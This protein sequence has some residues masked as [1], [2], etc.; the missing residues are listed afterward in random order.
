M[1]AIGSTTD[2]AL[3]V[4]LRFGALMLRAGGTASRTREIMEAMARRL[5]LEAPSINLTIGHVVIS[6]RRGSERLTAM[7][8]VGPPGVNV[9]CIGALERLAG[10]TEPATAPQIAARLTEIEADAP[11]YSAWQIV[12]AVGLASGGFAFLNG[13]GVPELAAAALGGGIGQALRSWLVRRAFTQFGTAALAAITAAAIYVLV[14]A[15]ANR[16]GFTFS[17]YAAG[18]I[19][20]VLFLVPGV[21]LIAGLFDLLQH[22]TMAALG[23]LAYGS[24]ILFIVASGLSIV[25]AFAGIELSRQPP[26]ELPYPL[27]LSLRAVASFIA[28]CAFAMA[29][30]SP[31]RTMLVAGVVALVVNSLRLVL[32]D[33]GMLL[34]PAAFIAALSVG[35][36]ASLASRRF[37]AQ[38]MAIVAAPIV[39]MIPGLYAFEMIVLFNLGRMNE[40][41]QASAGFVFVICALA[42]GLSMARLAVARKASPM[43]NEPPDRRGE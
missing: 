4:L 43:M 21:P 27:Q 25:T 1:S 23:R 32:V 31:P 8:D 28:A 11:H 18:F 5:K 39:I 20:T 41:L 3:D 22:Q 9:A 29:F 10:G 30:N 16:A 36:V 40:A 35:I 37:D 12:I 33:A 13:A 26:L 42:M 14:A 17:H 38:L 15:L 24:L 6:A 2:D 34:A 19:S 7:R